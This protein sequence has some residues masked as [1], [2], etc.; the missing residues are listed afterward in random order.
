[1]RIYGGE[2]SP[3]L[4]ASFLFKNTF[5]ISLSAVEWFLNWKG[6]KDKGNHTKRTLKIK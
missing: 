2:L 5:A 6:I 3:A 4:L 1:V